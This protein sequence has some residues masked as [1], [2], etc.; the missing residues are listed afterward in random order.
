MRPDG[1]FDHQLRR[2]SIADA[3]LVGAPYQRGASFGAGAARGPR[4]DPR[5]PRSPDRAVRAPHPDRAGL[6]LP[7]RAA[8]AGRGRRLAPEDMVAAVAACVARHE[9]FASCWAARMP[10]RSARCRRMPPRGRARR[11]HRAADRRPSRPARRRFRLQRPRPEPLRPFLRDAPRLRDGLSNLLGRHPGVCARRISL[12]R[13]PVLAGLRVGQ[14]RRACDRRGPRCDRDRARLPH[15]RRRRLRSCGCAGH[16]HAGAGR[17]LLGLRHPAGARA[18][19][20]QRRDRRRH[21]RGG[22]GSRLDASPSTPRRSSATICCATSC[23]SGMASWRLS[24]SRWSRSTMFTTDRP[25]SRS[26]RKRPAPSRRRRAR[27][28]SGRRRPGRCVGSIQKNVFWMPAQ[29]RLPGG[30]PVGAVSSLIMKLRPQ[31][32]GRPGK[33]SAS[34]ER[35]GFCGLQH[36]D[37]DVAHGVARHQR[38]RLGLQHLLPFSVPPFRIIR[39]NLR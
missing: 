17:R 19:P 1:R 14:R 9:A 30:R 18:V 11:R 22:A 35:A 21:R 12:R 27:S 32:L 10:C 8:D 38:H 33:N 29:A 31:L 6:P 16:R 5:L 15:D 36:H 23:S 3:V 4:G 28:A 26:R 37:P 2:S 39:M 13:R 34:S 24:S 20:H 25:P 7:D